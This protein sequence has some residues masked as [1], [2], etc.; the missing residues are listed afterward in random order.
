MDTVDSLRDALIN[1]GPCHHIRVA[2]GTYKVPDAYTISYATMN[3]TVYFYSQGSGTEDLPIIIESEDPD[4]MAEL[5]GLTTADSGYILWIN[6]SNWQIK[7][8]LLRNGGKGLMLDESSNSLVSGVEVYQVGDE[9][10]HLR[11]GTSNAVVENCIVDTTGLQQP[12]FGEGVYIGSDNSQWAYYD[13][14]CNN[15]TVRG[16]TL[17]NTG[18]EGVDVKEG[19]TGNLIEDCNIYGGGISGVNFADSFIDLKGDGARVLNN[20]FY[21]ESNSKVTRGVAIVERPL[22]PTATNNW[23][24]DNSFF[25]DDATGLMVHAYAG[26]NNYAWNNTRTPDGEEYKGNAPELYFSDP[27]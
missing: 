25:M 4:N 12:G 20:T 17:R 15:N 3:R 21:K 16:C 2:P 13:E 26:S 10:I 14:A 18:A 19:T 5:E 11:S 23:I 7:N 8:L 1:A 24:Y 27:R 6:G 22:G 9:G